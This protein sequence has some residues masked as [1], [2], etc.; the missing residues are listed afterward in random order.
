MT[1]LEMYLLVE[2]AQIR[3]QFNRLADW[4][5]TESF[6]EVLSG[7]IDEGELLV[8]T[9]DR[10]AR[11]VSYLLS[12]NDSLKMEKNNAQTNAFGRGFD[13]YGNPLPSR[14]L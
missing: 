6:A 8:L 12:E 3:E 2:I 10:L 4:D 7:V 9:N 11:E 14:G 5:R 1:D 13:F